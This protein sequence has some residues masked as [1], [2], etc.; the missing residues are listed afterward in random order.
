VPMGFCFPGTGK[1][2]DLPPRQE[3]AP[4]WRDMVLD[5]LE[6][7]ELTLI[8]GR[9]A[10]DWHQPKF[11][12]STVTQAVQCW[13]ENWPQQLILPHPSPRNNR[14]LKQNP[15]FEAEIIPMLQARVGQLM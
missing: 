9:Y 11:S 2:G 3:C 1:G 15:W 7:V 8:I 14:W 13:K 6:S 10:I 5:T 4:A 12:K